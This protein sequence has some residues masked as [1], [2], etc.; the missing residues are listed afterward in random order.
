MK[1]PHSAAFFD[2]QPVSWPAIGIL[3]CFLGVAH[4][5][6]CRA[7]D[8]L[9][10]ALGLLTGAA[11]DFT[12][13]SLHLSRDFPE[14]SLHALNGATVRPPAVPRSMLEPPLRTMSRHAIQP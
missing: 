14:R 11:G 5:L 10:D 8:F 6:F 4:L 3:Q 7:F 1:R 9:G 13:F 2:G 12:G